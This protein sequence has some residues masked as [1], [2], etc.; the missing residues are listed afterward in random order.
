[1]KIGENTCLNGTVSLPRLEESGETKGGSP[2][3]A[4]REAHQKL[5]RAV[6]NVHGLKMMTASDLN[7][8]TLLR[9]K[10]LILTRAAFEELRKAASGKKD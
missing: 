6:R 5:Y 4:D 7:A 9:Q 3:V 1:L 2:A 8:Y 10:K